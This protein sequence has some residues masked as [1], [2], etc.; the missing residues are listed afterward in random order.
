MIIDAARRCVLAVTTVA[1]IVP[2]IAAYAATEKE[3]VRF[4][5]LTRDGDP[6]YKKGRPYTGLTLREHHR[7]IEGIKVGLRESRIIG[8]A[9]GLAYKLEEIE[10][11]KDRIAT[12]AIRAVL[13]DGAARIFILDL[14]LEDVLE[15]GRAL[16]AEE[17]ILFNPRHQDDGLRGVDCSPVL[18]HTA[19]SYAMLMDALAQYLFKRNWKEVLALAGPDDS[20]THWNAA[21]TASARKFRLEIVGTRPFVLSNDPRQRD[22]TNFA[23]LT[24]GADYDVIFLADSVGEFG[25]YLPYQTKDARPVVGSEG[26]VASAWHWTWERHGAPQLNQRFDRIAERHMM[27]PDWAAWVA[28]KAVVAATQYTKSRDVAMLRSA[29]RSDDFRID[30]YLGAPSNFRPWNNQMRMNIL[31]HTHN[32]VIARA[33]IDGFLHQKNNLDTLGIDAGESTC[34]ME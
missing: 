7:A 13:S 18:F 9:A 23:L 8:R 22:Q 6:W 30:T 31:L 16:G 14:P 26:L 24:S 2:V 21:F 17:L 33:P 3:E 25:R 11:E 20:D 32:A 12:D 1:C 34:K 28:V 5:Y 4:V 19:P 27:G 15:A 29:L 10:L